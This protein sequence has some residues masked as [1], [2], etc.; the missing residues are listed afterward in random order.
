M[1]TFALPFPRFFL[2]APPA[3]TVRTGVAATGEAPEAD[4]VR[5][6]K[7]G[8]PDAFRR[9]VDRYRGYAVE[10]ASRIVRSRE[11]AEE[12]AQDAFVR[13]W[14][15]LP[16]FREEARFSTWLTRIVVRRALDAAQAKSRRRER[17]DPRDPVRLDVAADTPAGLADP[18]R[19]RL[20]R[21]LGDLEPLPR[22]VVT[23][24]YLGERRVDEVARILELPE[25]TVKTHLH[26]SRAALRRAWIRE[27]TKEE[28]LGLPR[29]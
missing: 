12:A 9:L 13:A 21:I 10:V 27:S 18:D 6:A 7:G 22:A 1:S 11:E 29:V 14:R 24:F 19:R 5:A 8:D 17:E 15:A 26:R 20:W 16:E 25:G 23:L 3:D 4:W 28:R 2:V